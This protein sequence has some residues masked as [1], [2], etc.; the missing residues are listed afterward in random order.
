[1]KP[2]KPKNKSIINDLSSNSAK[3]L[4]K[5]TTEN[6][7]KIIIYYTE[8]K[9]VFMVEDINDLNIKSFE[10]NISLEEFKKLDDNFFAF[11]TTEKVINLI[12]SCIQKENYSLDYD[13]NGKYICLELKYDFFDGG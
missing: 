11:R 10:L 3:F 4:I 6:C 2:K 9:F 12:K 5:K 7:F 8:D 13:E 1:M